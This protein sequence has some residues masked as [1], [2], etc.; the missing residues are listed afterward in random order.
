MEEGKVM[1]IATAL[2]VVL[3]SAVYLEGQQIQTTT[4][5]M[6]EPVIRQRL[7]IMGYTNVQIN[8]TNTLR[9]EIRANKQGQPVVL[10]LHP[11][12][13]AVHEVTPGKAPVRPW[14]MPIEPPENIRQ[15]RMPPH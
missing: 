8:K 14:T 13:G 11:Q 3:L 2:V 4:A 5:P 7:K 1:K 6:S 15:E 9:Y 12:T 10:N